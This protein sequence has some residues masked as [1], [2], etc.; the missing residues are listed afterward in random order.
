MSAEE[1][2]EEFRRLPVEEQWELADR[3]ANEFDDELTSEQL[4]VL[5][6]RA[7]KLRQHPDQGIPWKQVRAELK[8]RLE[9]RRACRGLFGSK[10]FISTASISIW[11]G[12]SLV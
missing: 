4:A 5:E 1:I 6:A 10:N 12:I 11:S 3:I 8:E 7:E 9:K 2:L